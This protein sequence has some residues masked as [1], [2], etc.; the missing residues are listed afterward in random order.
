MAGTIPPI[1]ALTVEDHGPI[2][3]VVSIVLPTIS[4]L[5][6]TVRMAMSQHKL[7][8]SKP[9]DIVFGTGL[10]RLNRANSYRIFLTKF[11]VLVFLPPSCHISAS[12]QAWEDTRKRLTK[13]R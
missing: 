6:A 3:T 11:S 2:N 13:S 12:G 7:S 4:I 5:I 1:A 9:D 8:Q 10:V